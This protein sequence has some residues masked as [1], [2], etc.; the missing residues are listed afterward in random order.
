MTKV[1]DEAHK[2]KLDLKKK[3]R[4]YQYRSTGEALVLA[5]ISQNHTDFGMNPHEHMIAKTNRQNNS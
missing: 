5:N 1:T 3:R 4:D 2:A